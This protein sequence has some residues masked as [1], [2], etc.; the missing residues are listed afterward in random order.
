MALKNSLIKDPTA[1]VLALPSVLNCA[2]NLLG[3]AKRLLAVGAAS[4]GRPIQS[5]RARLGRV[6]GTSLPVDLQVNPVKAFL[7]CLANLEL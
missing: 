1:A 2:R 7:L 5:L 6:N 4:S 3:K